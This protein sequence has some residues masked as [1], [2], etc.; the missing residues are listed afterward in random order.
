MKTLD[1]TIRRHLCTECKDIFHCDACTEAMEEDFRKKH[2][3][4]ILYTLLGAT[5]D[6]RENLTMDAHFVCSKC[7]TRRPE[8][9]A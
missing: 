6:D 3:S 2:R 7:A 1:E 9:V 8:Q 4:G 5:E